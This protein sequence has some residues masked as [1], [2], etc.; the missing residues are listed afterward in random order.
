MGCTQ[1]PGGSCWV[2][3]GSSLETKGVWQSLALPTW[4]LTLLLAAGPFAQSDSTS[5]S[6][7]GGQTVVSTQGDSGHI[8]LDFSEGRPH[9]LLMVSLLYSSWESP[10]V[11]VCSACGHTQPW[12]RALTEFWSW[13]SAFSILC[14]PFHRTF[15][16]LFLTLTVKLLP[17]LLSEG[18]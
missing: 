1:S 12:T 2:L 6:Q 4:G 3:G 8:C 13:A 17:S 11:A 16:F 7:E 10:R 18:E 5:P 14:S 15:W 9:P